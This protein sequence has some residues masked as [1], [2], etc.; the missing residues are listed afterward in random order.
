M[1]DMDELKE[2]RLRLA[3]RRPGPRSRRHL[4]ISSCPPRSGMRA[5]S[6]SRLLMVSK[7]T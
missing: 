5:K 1:S 7:S 4:K 3:V 6:S 2:G